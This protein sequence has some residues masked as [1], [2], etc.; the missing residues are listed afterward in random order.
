ML[1]EVLL[2]KVVFIFSS[3]MLL[4]FKVVVVEINF[5][6]GHIQLENKTLNIAVV[7]HHL[8]KV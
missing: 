2:E 6:T 5:E 8:F 7:F 3:A 1:G 4:E